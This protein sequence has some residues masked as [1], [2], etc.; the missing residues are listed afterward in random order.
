MLLLLKPPLRP[1]LAEG[2]SSVMSVP[3]RFGGRGGGGEGVPGA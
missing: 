2:G 3:A 1:T